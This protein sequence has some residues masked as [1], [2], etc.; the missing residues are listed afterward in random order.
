MN[1]GMASIQKNIN[2]IYRNK[3]WFLNK[4]S[5]DLHYNFKKH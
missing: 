4:M 2:G 3:V 1:G 5:L